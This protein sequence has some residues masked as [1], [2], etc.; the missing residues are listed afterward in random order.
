MSKAREPL[1][2]PEKR[3][4]DAEEWV[5]AGQ[6]KEA[7]QIPAKASGRVPGADPVRLNVNLAPDLH[8]QFKTACAA[9]GVKMADVV[10]ELVQGWTEARR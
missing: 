8:R 5:Q 3:T 6:A 2:M 4:Q 10:T 1:K 7:P 9:Q